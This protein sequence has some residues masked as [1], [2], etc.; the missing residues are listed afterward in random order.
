MTLIEEPLDFNRLENDEARLKCGIAAM[1]DCDSIPQIITDTRKNVEIAAAH[2]DRGNAAFQEGNAWVSSLWYTKAIVYATANSPDQA[3]AY[4]NRSAAF[5]QMA[6][7]DHCL[8]DIDRALKI[9]YPDNLKTKLYVRQAK[10]L[11]ALDQKV[12]ARVQESLAN[13]RVWSEQIDEVNREKV[14]RTLDS[15]NPESS[16]KCSNIIWNNDIFIPETPTDNPK[17]L[18]ASAAIKLKYTKKLGRHVVATRDLAAGETLAVQ[19]AFVTIPMYG[20]CM[21]LSTDNIFYDF[22]WN[23]AVR[24]LSGVPC[25]QCVNVIYCNEQ[26]RDKA[27]NEYHDIE[28]PIINSMLVATTSTIAFITC[29]ITIK[30]IKEAGT[31]Q[32]L[33]KKLKKINSNTGLH[34]LFFI[35]LS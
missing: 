8:L 33:K 25:P 21:C 23:C 3:R 31:L 1:L 30:A 4:A 24:I 2:M 6:L 5:I 9:G 7:Y 19:K 26:C 16:P 35:N 14:I 29:R 34:L 15:L 28:C 18:G 13:A 20:D 32:A 22:C 17:I 11:I 10:S 12:S 27:W